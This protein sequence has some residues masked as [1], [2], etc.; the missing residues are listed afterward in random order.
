MITQVPTCISALKKKLKKLAL[1]MPPKKT[2]WVCILKAR[3]SVPF[4]TMLWMSNT[5]N[6]SE[7]QQLPKTVF[8]PRSTAVIVA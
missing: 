6:P 1:K 3:P 8:T 7:T 2:C 4:E 5:E